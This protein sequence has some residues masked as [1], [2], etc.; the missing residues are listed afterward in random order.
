MTALRGSASLII[1][2]TG[3]IGSG[4]TAATDIFQALGI[5]VVDADRVSREVVE[6][7]SPALSHI[8]ARYGSGTILLQD[9]SLNRRALRD[10]IFGNPV[11]KKWLEALLHPLIRE[12][13]V[14]Q[15]RSSQSPYTILASPLLLETDQ[16]TLCSRVLVIDAPETLQLERTQLRDNADKNAVQAIMDSQ[17]GRQQRT[18]LADDVIVNDAGLDAL[19]NAVHELHHKYLELTTHD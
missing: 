17:M 11:E 9:G 19:K 10:I 6:V 15:L 13:I 18:A 4:K 5:R 14:K 3:G 1:G 2:L 16:Q 8:A 12:E 7:G